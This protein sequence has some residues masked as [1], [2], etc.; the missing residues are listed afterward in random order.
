MSIIHD[1]D[2]NEVGDIELSYKQKAVLE[3]GEEVVVIFR[4]P[5]TVRHVIGDEQG[6]FVLHKDGDRI[7]VHD[8]GMLRGYA[9]LQ[10]TVKAARGRA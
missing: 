3:T 8:A 1:R 4:T 5:Q 6:S 10:R 2:G 9:K 7:I